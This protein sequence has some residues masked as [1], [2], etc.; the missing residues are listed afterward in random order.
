MEGGE[1]MRIFDALC[2][3]IRNGEFT[4]EDFEDVK[5]WLRE[6]LSE[7]EIIR[8]LSPVLKK[9]LVETLL[10]ILEY[11]PNISWEGLRTYL[12]CNEE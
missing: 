10:T 3:R 7:F 1:I 9:P 6:K 2:S 5:R 4:R 12:G 8:R 11:R